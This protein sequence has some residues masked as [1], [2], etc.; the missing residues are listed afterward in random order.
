MSHEQRCAAVISAGFDRLVASASPYQACKE[1]VA[2]VI[3]ERGRGSPAP[4]LR[5]ISAQGLNSPPCYP[6]E[7]PG[8]KDHDK[9]IYQLVA[10]GTGGGSCGGRLEFSGRQLHDSHGLVVARRALLR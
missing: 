3:L 6:A 10:L 1:T 8:T 2:A 5:G 4:C 9:E 7:V